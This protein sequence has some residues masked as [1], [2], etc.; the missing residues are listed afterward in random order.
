MREAL[1]PAILALHGGWRWI[2]LLLAAG[3]LAAAFQAWRRQQPRTAWERRLA[4]L[5]VGALDLQLVLG[6]VLYASLSPLTRSAF[7]SGQIFRDRE[8]AF[9]ALVHGPA[10]LSAVVLG[11]AGKVA[12]ADGRTPSLRQG[13]AL[14]LFALTLL[15]LL[16]AVPWWRPLL[17]L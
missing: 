14:L 8:A 3:T 17:R 1:Y 11:H 13:R 4:T 10:M 15:I 16:A 6:L 7:A 9:F 2:V 5:F 12:A